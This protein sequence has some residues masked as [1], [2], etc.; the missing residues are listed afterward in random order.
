MRIVAAESLPDAGEIRFRPPT[1]ALLPSEDEHDVD[2]R[3]KIEGRRSNIGMV[4]QHFALVPELTVAENLALLDQ[5]GFR[6]I[7]PQRINGDAEATIE[8]SGIVLGDV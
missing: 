7:S 3:S 2:R 4:H 5:T 6:F 8:R 1:I